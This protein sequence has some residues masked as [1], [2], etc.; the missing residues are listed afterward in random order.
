MLLGQATTVVSGGT[1]HGSIIDGAAAIK[2]LEDTLRTYFFP[3]G[4]SYTP[5]ETTMDELALEF[6]NLNTPTSE[7][8][9]TGLVGYVIHP[10]R[11]LVTLRQ[12]ARQPFLWH[13]QLQ[14]AG[15]RLLDGKGSPGEDSFLDNFTSKQGLL[16]AITD[17]LELLEAADTVGLILAGGDTLPGSLIAGTVLAN[18]L[19]QGLNPAMGGLPGLSQNPGSPGVSAKPRKAGECLPQAL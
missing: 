19:P 1:Q 13:Y 16:G 6:M 11:G 17:R 2:D 7:Q 8:D 12:D 9:A 5:A 18:I 4:S 15:L 14:F 10:H 3:E